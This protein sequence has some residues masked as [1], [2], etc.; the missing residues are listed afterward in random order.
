MRN[1]LNCKSLEKYFAISIE[2]LAI[3]E[4]SDPPDTNLD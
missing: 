1:S 3:L 2:T 4:R